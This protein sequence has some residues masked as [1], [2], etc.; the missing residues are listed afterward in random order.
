MNYV[1]RK[2]LERRYERGKNWVRELTRH[3]GVSDY[4]GRYDTS[5][6]DRVLKAGYRPLRK[7]T[8]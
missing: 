2:E 3:P 8:K 7:R 4:G 5:E 6:T 1:S